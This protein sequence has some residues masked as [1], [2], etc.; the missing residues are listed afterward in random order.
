MDARRPRC[1]GGDAAP[2]PARRIETVIGIRRLPY[3]PRHLCQ[4]VAVLGGGAASLPIAL[5]RFR[6]IGCQ[7]GIAFDESIVWR[8]ASCRIE[9]DAPPRVSL[10]PVGY[11]RR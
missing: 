1:R 9:A 6:R 11:R 2:L 5:E 8:R 4:F 7:A 3:A 10:W